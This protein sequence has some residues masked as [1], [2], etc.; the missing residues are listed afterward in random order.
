MNAA[1]QNVRPIEISAAEIATMLADRIE[2]L[3]DALQLAGHTVNGGLLPLNPTRADRKAGS[4]VIQLQGNKR[5]RWEDYAVGHYGDA[6]DLIVYVMFGGWP[7]TR[8]GKAEALRWGK[9]W[10]GIGDSGR[11][12]P[13]DS[14]RLRAAKA[15]MD[16]QRSRAEGLALAAQDKNRRSAQAMFL[17]A[18]PLAA[19]L[20]GWTYLTEARGIDLTKLER[21]PW[22][23]RSHHAMRHVETDQVTPCLISALMFADGSFGG[24]HRI[25]LEKDGR[26]KLKVEGPHIPVKKIWPKGW[27][28]AVIPISRGKTQLAPRIAA[29][30]G[31]ADECAYAEGVEDAFSAALL[32]PEWR[33]SAVGASANFASIEPATSASAVIALRDNDGN[34]KT[35]AAVSAKVQGLREKA[36][37][38]GLPFFETWPDRG[39]QDF[40]DMMRGVRS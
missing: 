5:G 25:F 36:E 6:L 39:F 37:A 10:L 24:V 18:Q 15:A 1:L 35:R 22:A 2:S 8:E 27:H 12:G 23:V 19:G 7:I 26:S 11:I 40:N 32:C 17:A 34:R 33:V 13:D 16:D 31:L 4:F 28:G 38:R 29:E 20:P 14:K 21:L 30:R 3:C 9:R